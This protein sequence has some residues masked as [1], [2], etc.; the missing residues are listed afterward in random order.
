MASDYGRSLLPTIN[1]NKRKAIELPGYSTDK[2]YRRLCVKRAFRLIM[3][4]RDV[5]RNFHIAH[6]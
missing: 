5:I 3:R 6:T 2:L 4:Y 1:M